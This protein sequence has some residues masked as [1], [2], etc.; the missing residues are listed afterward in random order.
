MAMPSTEAA[1][2]G[3]FSGFVGL[4]VFG[5]LIYMFRDYYISWRSIWP[6]WPCKKDDDDEEEKHE[7]VV[8]CLCKKPSK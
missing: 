3:F 2:I 7:V 4:F 5:W 1:L 6:Y 8:G